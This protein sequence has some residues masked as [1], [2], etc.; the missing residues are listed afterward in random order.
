MALL[1]CLNHG[2]LNG[3]KDLLNS[4]NINSP[5]SKFGDPPLYHFISY[6]TNKGF[7]FAYAGYSIIKVLIDHKADIN[8]VRDGKN[9]LS[10]LCNSRDDS[11]LKMIKL[12]LENKIQTDGLLL[13]YPAIKYAIDTNNVKIVKLLLENNI[14][15]TYCAIKCYDFWCNDNYSIMTKMLLEHT[16]T[17]FL[18]F[19]FLRSYHDVLPVVCNYGCLNIFKQITI[20]DEATSSLFSL[21]F[22]REIDYPYFPNKHVYPFMGNHEKY[23]NFMTNRKQSISNSSLLEIVILNISGFDG[24]CY[25]RVNMLGDKKDLNDYIEMAKILINLGAN[26]NIVKIPT[27][28]IPYITEVKNTLCRYLLDFFPK[29]LVDIVI[30]YV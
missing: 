7:S 18:P 28:L 30:N 3:L 1:K 4:K 9:V 13:E 8:Y 2:D 15:I 29:V 26:T 16:P 25:C 11:V 22:D 20:P 6:I 12:L 14:K 17:N 21:F 19:I 24:M 10:I 27:V 23:C 5:V